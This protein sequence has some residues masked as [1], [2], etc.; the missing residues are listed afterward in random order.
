MMPLSV[1]I[2]PH[3]IPVPYKYHPY[4]STVRTIW[5][6]IM[7]PPEA[8]SSDD[9]TLVL[10]TPRASRI[11]GLWGTV[12][13]NIT[14]SKATIVSPLMPRH[15][16]T[17]HMNATAQTMTRSQSCHCLKNLDAAAENPEVV[18]NQEAE[19]IA[20][21]PVLQP[22]PLITVQHLL[23]N[24]KGMLTKAVQVWKD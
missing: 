21:Y 15:I 17:Y 11:W 3:Q 2:T 16:H 1:M 10:V 7:L 6:I 18:E 20:R 9:N 12:G 14:D 5:I 19:A 23:A 24:D 8:I 4:V 22:W 13:C